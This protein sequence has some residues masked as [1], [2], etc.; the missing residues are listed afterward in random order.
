MNILLLV[1]F[2]VAGLLFSYLRSFIVKRVREQ[3]VAHIDEKEIV[4]IY[5]GTKKE[6]FN[7]KKLK[8]IFILTDAVEWIKSIKEIL[9]LRK[10]IIYLTIAGLVYGYGWYKGRL[11]KPVQFNL[12]YEKEFMLKIDGHYLHKPKNSKQLEII[13]KN[14]KKIKDVT[15]ADI[16]EL[17]KKLK[18]VGFELKPIGVLGMGVGESENSF[19]GGAGV[20]F[21]RYWSWRLETFLTNKGIYLGTS[22]KLNRLNLNNS[23]IGVGAGKGFQGDNRVI[24]YY[25]WE[26]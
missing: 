12:D 22:Y 1:S 10:M 17:Q 7:P 19:E 16:P 9:D 26:F 25:K 20:S 5:K 13:D 18:P 21:L 8:K 11:G 23:S 6:K 24:F 15:I 2:F 3:I 4:E 14:G